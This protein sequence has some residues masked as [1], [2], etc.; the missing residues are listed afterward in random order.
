[1]DNPGEPLPRTDRV[2]LNSF[3]C[4]FIGESLRHLED[5]A[6]TSSIH[7]N[8]RRSYEGAD[9][10]EVDDFPWSIQLNELSAEL[11]GGHVGTSQVDCQDLLK[12]VLSQHNSTHWGRMLEHG[13]TNPYR[14]Q[15]VVRDIQD[16]TPAHYACA[17]QEDVRGNTAL[18]YFCKTPPQLFAVC[19]IALEHLEF[20]TCALNGFCQAVSQW[21]VGQL[22]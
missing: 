19:Y 11:L 3:R 8:V 14:V 18:P 16:R 12:G 1:M 15:I 21:I 9:G 22:N 7:A 17:I 4:P 2:D 10:A 13:R 20:S 5:P 6:L